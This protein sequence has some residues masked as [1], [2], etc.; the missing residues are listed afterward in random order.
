MKKIIFKRIINYI[1]SMIMIFAMCGYIPEKQ[2]EVYALS[3]ADA[4]AQIYSYLT[5]KMNYNN[6]VACGILANIECECSFN[7]VL[8]EAG[9]GVGYGII[10]WSGSRKT[11]LKN[12]CNKN[13]Y[14]Y[15]TLEGQLRFMMHEINNYSNT[16]NVINNAPN[17]SVGAG[18]VASVFCYDYERPYY[19][20]KVHGEY[21]AYG[22]KVGVNAGGYDFFPMYESGKQISRV[23]PTERIGI[24]ECD[25]REYLA[26]NKYWNKY[27][28]KEYWTT[29]YNGT[30]RVVGTSSDGQLNLR[31][32]N[33]SSSSVI[34]V[35]YNGQTV[36]ME[37][38]T[39]DKT[40]A[41]VDFNGTKGY[42]RWNGNLLS[43][44]LIPDKP[45]VSITSGTSFS[46]TLIS[47]NICNLASYYE[48]KVDGVSQGTTTVTSCSVPLHS[49]WHN[50]EVIAYSSN[51]S[52]NS[53]GVISFE[54]AKTYPEKASVSVSPG[55]SKSTTYVSWNDCGFA[56]S[57]NMVI[58][59][60]SGTAV[61]SQ[62]GSYLDYSIK[63]TA[64]SYYAIVT[65]RNNTDNTDTPSDR[66]NFT[67]EA[68]IPSTPTLSVLP[69]NNYTDSYFTWNECEYADNYKLEVT[70]KDT[71]KQMLSKTIN[72]TAYNQIFSTAG[73]Y[74][75]K[76]YAVNTQDNVSTPSQ[77][78]DFYVESADCTEFDLSVAGRSD[79]V[80]VLDWTVSEHATQYDVYR[81]EGGKYVLIGTTSETT[82]T[83]AGLY[84]DTA[85][86]YYVK[87]SNQW[88]EMDSN[89]VATETIILTLNGSGSESD[90]YIIDSVEDLEIA[91][92]LVND[93]T[94]TKVFGNACYQLTTDIDLGGVNWIS[95]GTESCPFNGIFNGNYY[96]I[97]GISSNVFG[98]CE[99]AVIENIVTYGN[100]SSTESNVGGIAGR[101]GNGRIENCAFYGNVSGTNNVGG[102]VGSMANSGSLVRCYQ[103]GTVSGSN[104]V[105]GIA[106]QA[107]ASSSLSYCYHAGGT[108]S[109][110][111]KIGGIAG[112][113]TGTANYTNCYY[114]NSNCSYG[115]S[116]G[117]NAGVVAVN[118]TVLKNLTET[119]G[120][121][122]TVNPDSTVNNGYPVF[123]WEITTYEFKG[124]G[125]SSSPYQI[126]TA[127]DLQ[128]LSEFVNDTYLNV[129]YGK[130][131]YIQTADIDMSKV[132]WAPIGTKENPFSGNYN[133]G[134][135][136][137]T[138]LSNDTSVAYG[139][140][141]GYCGDV[142]VKNLIVCGNIS[143]SDVAGGILGE[144][145][146][147]C[148][149]TEVAFMGT[150]NGTDAGGLVGKLS[151]RGTI[152]Q[153]YHNGIVKGTNA[154]G[155]I[156]QTVYDSNITTETF[157]IRN[158][159]HT[160]GSISGTVTGGI[161]GAG[162]GYEL[163]N[164]FYLKSSTSST[165]NGTAAN[166]TVM[167][168][169]SETIE[170]PFTDN[171][172]ANLNNGYPVFTWQISRYEFDGMGTE[173]D[174]YLIWTA[175]DLIA[176]QEY[177]NNPAYHDTYANAYY[178]QICD[179]DLGD[180]EWTPIGM[181]EE[182]AFNGVYDGNCFTIY[183]LSACGET[184][185]GLFGQVG[186]TS[187]G[188]NAGI[189]NIII[190]YGTSS[191]AT[192]VVGG[193]AAVLMNG[194]TADSCAVIGDLYGDSGVGGVIGIVRKSGAI[195][196]SYHNGS[197]NGNSKVG[198]I[199]GY[200]ESGTARIEN[201]YHTVGTVEGS[202]HIGAITGYVSGT[203]KIS[204]CYYLIG[205]CSGAVDGSSNSGVT[206]TNA[207]V[208]KTL[209]PSLGEVYMD[210]IYDVY[211][212]DGYPIFAIAAPYVDEGE[213]YANGDVNADGEF[214][215]SDVVLL[216]KWLLA[217]PNVKLA[218]WQAA[219]FYE[220]SI[221]NVFDLCLMKQALL[222]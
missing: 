60:S 146:N 165:A 99:S 210:N 5:S 176:L 50:A 81:Y 101:I 169:L 92:N 118:E 163:E 196:N 170:A 203:V 20:D 157:F 197:V 78:I 181:S 109:G 158:S 209:A 25:Y 54:V 148:N 205:T 167:K 183:G 46:N 114:L 52:P 27:G 10:Q 51:G 24:N 28:N 43:K 122:F 140:L 206:V 201:C 152:M 7:I 71:N 185:S 13:G 153:S 137:I 127:E 182:L 179:I 73:N 168:A 139:G 136:N 67:V 69:G 72:G 124:D 23:R 26:S 35:M 86:K 12:W 195:T 19:R 211:F 66:K 79:S 117:T 216:R 8:K 175:D 94:T 141:F 82:F 80:I 83:D 37:K 15:N 159:Y 143:A 215:I 150:V 88:T 186:A 39:T 42:C 91:R 61:A 207:T 18:E 47:W 14:A 171:E 208:M 104:G 199:L 115:V 1:L 129:K 132:T 162:K 173:E 190:E 135:R 59:N 68:A 147:S 30:Y 144:V 64:G 125:T 187:N 17:T 116:N 77:T 131:Y 90:P 160:N 74:T 204:N 84:I 217:V 48:V 32:S 110:T 220:D 22:N 212:N 166:E 177:V 102:I 3:A 133:G 191:S 55:N 56:D 45:G 164:C 202:E 44:D 156:G 11:D 222:G 188:R 219:D 142:S 178:E 105:G 98:Y 192:G 6:A 149:L 130:A 36:Q 85:Y 172:N 4:E 95:I 112:Q 126:G 103:I 108:V 189:Y 96:T 218:D 87:A 49:G 213:E 33:S 180:M 97:S 107:T 53:S 63:L 65:T 138:G 193:A 106:G 221:L 113:Q 21:N 111:S 214:N 200:V 194:A 62:N 76:V 75:A 31:S 184:Y 89:E 145:K 151:G 58:Y 154:G 16:S 198:G 119:L 9:N 41:Y 29:E 2:T 121:P 123:S 128:Y 155:L 34:A 134:Y 93:S 38:C 161:I 120:T 100:I 40:W 70:N 174:P 57:Y